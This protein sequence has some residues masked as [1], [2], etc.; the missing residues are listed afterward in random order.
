[1]NI[2]STVAGIPCLIEV[3]H[4]FK[5]KPLGQNCDSDL[6]CY[7]YTEIE[8]EV[9]DRRGRP[10]QWLEKKL[11]DKDAGRINLEIEEAFLN[12]PEESL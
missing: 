10:A 12:Q 5:Q 11:T 4:F 1:M 3:T 7:G 8:F 6:D 2:S 9:Q